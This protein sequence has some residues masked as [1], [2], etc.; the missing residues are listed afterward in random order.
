MIDLDSS[1][2]KYNSK[3]LDLAKTK[4]LA[5]I[6][7]TFHLPRKFEPA[8]II[9]SGN[10][11]TNDN[12]SCNS[13]SPSQKATQAYE[14]Y[15]KGKKPIEVAIELGLPEYKAT[16]YYRE[17]LDLTGLYDLTLLYEER[18]HHIPSFL[19]LHRILEREGIDDEKDIANV[20]KYANELPNLQKYCQS[21]QN[22]VRDL[23]YQN[24]KLERD[25]Q[26]RKRQIAELI[27]VENMH[28]HNVDSLQDDI[29]HLLSERSS[30]QQFVSRFRNSNEKY[31]Q[32]KSIAEGVVNRLL[33]E[34]K[35][36]LTSTL[37]AVVE[38]LR[39]NPDRYAVIYN[40]KYDD[41]CN[42]FDCDGNIA[43][44]TSSSPSITIAP[45]NDNHYYDQYRE[46]ILEIARSFLRILTNQI[47]DNTMVGAVQE[48]ESVSRI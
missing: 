3:A 35:S 32:I 10:V 45:Q 7:D 42:I 44:A 2:F 12:E 48:K 16:N 20:L 22:Q 47:V 15:D 11:I 17:Y 37:I 30:L 36:L 23:K 38:A 13:K 5:K 21:H 24:L 28:K 6:Q 34:R 33:T 25:I 31:L 4:T 41:N 8:T 18:K 19:K 1:N 29:E 14:L 46:G 26:V 40:S 39:M 43:T 9:W 27:E